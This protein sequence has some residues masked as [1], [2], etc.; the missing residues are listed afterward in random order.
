SLRSTWSGKQ[1][2]LTFSTDI[3]TDKASTTKISAIKTFYD[4]AVAK[5]ILATKLVTSWSGTPSH[6]NIPSEKLVYDELV[7]LDANKYDKN[8]VDLLLGAKED[9]TNK[10]SNIDTDKTSTTKYAN[11]KAIYDWAVG[12]F[13]EGPSSATDNAL[14]RYDGTTGKKA[15]DS[16]VSVDDAGNMIANTF[17]PIN[18][19]SVTRDIDG[20][21]V[22]VTYANGR[23][24]SITRVAGLITKYEDAVYEYVVN[25]TGVTFD[26]ITINIK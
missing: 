17:I 8:A 5:F 10:S 24:V 13:I 22:T 7:N 1:D 3:E 12:K 21:I 14:M 2:A 4:W 23:V 11:V 16:L 18:S 20:N 25:R 15:Q 6:A 19:Y 9:I 26:G